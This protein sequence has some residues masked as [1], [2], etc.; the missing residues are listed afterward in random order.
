METQIDEENV[1]DV[2]DEE[3]KC[4]VCLELMYKPVVLACGHIC[5]FWCVF[6]TMNA[7]LESHCPICR[8]PYNHF[9]NVCRLLHFVIQTLYPIAY[10]KREIQVADE[11]RQHGHSSPQFLEDI[12]AS[13]QTAQLSSSGSSYHC[14]I[15][16]SAKKEDHSFS[17][18]LS[19][20]MISDKHDCSKVVS[21]GPLDAEA[22]TCGSKVV[23]EANRPDDG[24]QHSTPK[25]FS[26][27][28]FYC[29]ACKNLLFQPVV[30]NCGHVH[31]EHCLSNQHN[32]NLKCHVCESP[33]PNGLPKICLVLDNLIAEQFPELHAE[34]RESLLKQDDNEKGGSSNTASQTSQRTTKTDDYALWWTGRGP[35]VHIG[36]GCDYCGMSPII[37]ERYKCLDCTEKIGFD[38][39]ETCYLR[40]SILPGRFNQQHRLDH[41][42][43]IK[44]PDIFN[45]VFVRQEV[46]E[47]DDDDDD[48]G[49]SSHDAPDDMVDGR[50]NTA[51][52]HAPPPS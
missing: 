16:S 35:K 48:D 15:N 46:G 8:H 28:D 24:Y 39:C 26:S 5:C 41:R 1:E 47:S 33:N 30:L 22:S 50:S 7:V 17:D 44:Q 4:C 43:E 13:F 11:E 21:E 45:H 38:L 14:S 34:R 42:F 10:K 27:V 31:C 25:K 6:R 49:Y 52:P 12:S 9:P 3:F 36:V 19:Q 37:G 29:P 32:G 23:T 20:S 18:D 2:E 40:S 51:I